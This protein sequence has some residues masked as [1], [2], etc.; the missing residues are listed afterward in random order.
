M[1]PGVALVQQ[2]RDDFTYNKQ[3]DGK[4]G[5]GG[6]LQA[7]RQMGT[8]RETEGLSSRLELDDADAQQVIDH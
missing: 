2:G 5:H 1:Q 4:Q 8:E 7:P 3:R 6:P